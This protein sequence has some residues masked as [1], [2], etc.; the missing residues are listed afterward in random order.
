MN[1]RLRA[2]AG[3]AG[4]LPSLGWY[5][6]WALWQLGLG[7]AP[8]MEEPPTRALIRGAW[9]EQ[10]LSVPVQG[11]RRKLR[12]TPFGELMLSEHGNWRHGH[13]QAI[14][15]A[16][17]AWPYFHFLSD[18]FEQIY[19]RPAGSLQELCESLHRAFLAASGL[20]ESLD[21]LRSHPEAQESLR[22]ASE[23]PD[24]DKFNPEV[25]AL[26]LLFA[27]G[28]ESIFYLLAK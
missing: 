17:G 6:R 5:R 20:Q 15:S 13:W 28:R 18:E 23:L 9:G 19:T 10:S 8:G 3:T 1:P 22:A 16:Y 12:S 27:K 4:Y 7:E 2:S 11:G 24:F 26:E 25:S 21:Y 14:T